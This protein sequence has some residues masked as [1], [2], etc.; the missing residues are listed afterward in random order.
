MIESKIAVGVGYDFVIVSS[1]KVRGISLKNTWTPVKVDGEIYPLYKGA[2]Y[3]D[4]AKIDVIMDNPPYPKIYKIAE[5]TV[6]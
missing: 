6:K 1:E 4:S 5:H 3:V 2:E